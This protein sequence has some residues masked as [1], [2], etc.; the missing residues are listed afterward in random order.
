MDSP[1]GNLDSVKTFFDAL[2]KHDV[3][4]L[5][6]LLADDIV[7]TI[8]LSN[9]G[10][11]EPF[12]TYEGKEAVVGYLG[13]IVQNFS[14]T[15]LVDKEFTVSEDGGKVFVESKGDLIQAGTEA[16]YE[17]RYVFKFVFR[18]GLITHIR[19]YANPI[20]FAKLVGM[21]VG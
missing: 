7:E 11:S 21:P 9:T 15:V 17:N 19:E 18:N 20:T 13:T 4:L 2:E 1:S 3:S 5:T 14:R 16:P 8:P 12:A 10:A 6:P